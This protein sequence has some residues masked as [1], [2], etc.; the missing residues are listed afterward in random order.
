MGKIL[1]FTS[2][3]TWDVSLASDFINENSWK[4]FDFHKWFHL[5]CV[6]GTWQTIRKMII[7]NKWSLVGL[8]KIFIWIFTCE[9][10][11]I[12]YN[13]LYGA[14]LLLHLCKRTC[15]TGFTRW[16]T[17]ETFF[18]TEGYVSVPH[19]IDRRTKLFLAELGRQHFLNVANFLS[20]SS[21]F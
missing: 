18:G 10:A 3:F 15:P 20:L 2:D 8:R 12:P 11:D 9:N 6:T 21:L 7:R 5:G 17:S 1:I 14:S 13:F 4:K 19:L 16:F